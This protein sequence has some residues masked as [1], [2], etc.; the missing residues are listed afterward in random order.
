[1]L[2][3]AR[4]GIATLAPDQLDALRPFDTCLLANAIEAMGIRLRN[5]GYTRPGL[6]C[7]TGG[8]ATPI[9]GYAA[10]SRVRTA[11]PPMTAGRGLHRSYYYDRTDW[12][13]AMQQLPTP[14]LAV[15]QDMDWQQHGTMGGGSGAVAGEV[16]AAIL[17]ALGCSGLITNG[18][19]R[20]L[21][22]VAALPFPMFARE[23]S[24]SHAYIHMVEFGG[25][26]VEIFG[27][28]IQTGDLLCADCHGV[29]SIP[30]E[31]AADL[32]AVAR[33]IAAR[34]R[35]VVDLCQSPGFSLDKLRDAIQQTPPA[36]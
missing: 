2:K 7:L 12:W 34:E 33:D 23:V 27:L 26:P 22:A 5:E 4:P 14:R 20:D 31:I 36:R 25:G 3:T 29:L 18:A 30:L 10:T 1:M 21:P 19:V 11:E 32:P 28:T 9:F 17:K 16:H 13:P 8:A 24:V 15:I 6:R 35:R